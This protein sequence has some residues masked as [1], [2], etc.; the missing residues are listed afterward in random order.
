MH[1]EF[2]HVPEHVALQAPQFARTLVKSASH[3]LV[4]LPSQNL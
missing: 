2:E 4:A 3:P 1:V